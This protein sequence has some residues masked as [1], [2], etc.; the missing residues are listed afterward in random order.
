[1][2]VVGTFLFFCPKNTKNFKVEKFKKS[3]TKGRG[4]NDE[5]GV[6]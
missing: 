2:F 4:E 6:K 1:L 3:K 5:N